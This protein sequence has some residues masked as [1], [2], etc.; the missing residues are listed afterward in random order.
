L[1]SKD[2]KTLVTFLHTP[3]GHLLRRK[4][5]RRIVAGEDR[6]GHQ[7]AIEAGSGSTLEETV[8]HLKR[9]Q[10]VFQLLGQKPTRST[11]PRSTASSRGPKTSAA[12]STTRTSS[13]PP[14]SPPEGDEITRYGSLIASGETAGSQ[15]CREQ[16]LTEEK[17]ADK[18]L[19]SISQSKVNL[20][21][22]G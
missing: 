10:Q 12:R 4:Q 20:R 11:A 22:A 18:K 21:A 15:R 14:S 19:A 9:L 13:T 3:Q 6:E 8:G 7:G 17:A 5:D 16:T 1:F 2:S